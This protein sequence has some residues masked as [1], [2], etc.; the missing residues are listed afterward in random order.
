MSAMKGLPFDGVRSLIRQSRSQLPRRKRRQRVLADPAAAGAPFAEDDAPCGR[1]E[2]PHHSCST[3]NGPSVAPAQE[4]ARNEKRKMGRQGW[5][6]FCRP[7]PLPFCPG[8][9]GSS[10]G[11]S[12][13]CVTR[14]MSLDNGWPARR[15]S[16][17]DHL[18]RCEGVPGRCNSQSSCLIFTSRFTRRGGVTRLR[19]ISGCGM[20]FRRTS[21]H[22]AEGRA[23][24]PRPRPK[25]RS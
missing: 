18:N 23:A 24:S 8:M 10:G 1:P 16:S 7:T 17:P 25:A 11:N 5:P 20:P 6:E 9:S 14:G 13:D 12:V 22:A 15:Q 3:R 21:R 19:G 2:G 4:D